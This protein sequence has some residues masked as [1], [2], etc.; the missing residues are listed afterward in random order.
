MLSAIRK[1]QG[2]F[3]S[4][5]GVDLLVKSHCRKSSKNFDL[6]MF[7]WT[8][9]QIS[10]EL[11]TGEAACS[12]CARRPLCSELPRVQQEF[13]LSAKRRTGI[14]RR[15]GGHIAASPENEACNSR[16]MLWVFWCVFFFLPVIGYRYFK[17]KLDTFKLEG[18]LLTLIT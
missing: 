10:V 18:E 7:S 8:P 13:C 17:F 11:K 16:K 12:V 9:P 6:T 15:S 1:N 3:M 14:Q 4:G 5:L 2:L